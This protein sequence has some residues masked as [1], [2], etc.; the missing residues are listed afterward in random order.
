L[1]QKLFQ[2][3]IGI[4]NTFTSCVILL[5]RRDFNFHYIVVLAVSGKNANCLA[6]RKTCLYR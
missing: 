2:K 6:I 4:M 1:N 3:K 5:E